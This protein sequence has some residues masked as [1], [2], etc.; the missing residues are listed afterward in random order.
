MEEEKTGFLNDLQNVAE[1]GDLTAF[2]K[3]LMEAYTKYPEFAKTTTFKKIAQRL[4][5]T[6][7]IANSAAAVVTDLYD[8][9]LNSKD[10]NLSRQD[11]KKIKYPIPPES[12][13]V[14]VLRD[15]LTESRKLAGSAGLTQRDL[16][17]R[18]ADDYLAQ[19][20]AQ[21]AAATGGNSGNVAA[22]L[23]AAAGS[24]AKQRLVGEQNVINAQNLAEGRTDNLANALQS[25]LF[26]Q[27][28]TQMASAGLLENRAGRQ[29]NLV[30]QDIVRTKQGRRNALVNLAQSLSTTLAGRPMLR[31]GLTNTYNSYFNNTLT[32]NPADFS[33]AKDP[34]EAIY[35][36]GTRFGVKP[37]QFSMNLLDNSI[38]K[39]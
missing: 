28:N 26:N 25:A 10:L 4:S 24:A 31:N 7:P 29:E 38:Y 19:V 32:Y 5:M 23:Q 34:L 6:L 11:L 3:L 18:A 35:M 2:N 13:D 1:S 36:A 9:I 33:A 12:P 17:R 39:K 20:R 16:A 21:A 8:F 22:M 37:L 14:K 27:F 30:Y 15:R